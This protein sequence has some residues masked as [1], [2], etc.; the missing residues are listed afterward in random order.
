M[1]AGAHA[2][3]LGRFDAGASLA[4]AEG[5]QWRAPTPEEL[6]ALTREPHA[7]QVFT[8]PAWVR[9]RLEALPWGEGEAL[10]R[11]GFERY[12]AEVL[13]WLRFLGFDPGPE[14]TLQLCPC[15]A[16]RELAVAAD[17]ARLALNVGERELRVVCADTQEKHWSL[18]LPPGH[19]ARCGA[20]VALRVGAGDPGLVLLVGPLR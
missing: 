19:A 12:S 7:L 6:E 3:Y 5:D 1:S 15:A 10:E 13:E 14:C 18:A 2:H 20:P 16:G 9:R 4:L 8:C 17:P 11:E